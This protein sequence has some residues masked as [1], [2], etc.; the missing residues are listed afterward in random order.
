MNKHTALIEHASKTK[1]EQLH[2]AL[3][4][5]VRL[6]ADL[7]EK[8]IARNSASPKMPSLEELRSHFVAEGHEPYVDFAVIAYS[9]IARHI[10]A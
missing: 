6:N 4:D 3:Q 1:I 10:R 9:F 5:Q 2:R 7:K 8:L